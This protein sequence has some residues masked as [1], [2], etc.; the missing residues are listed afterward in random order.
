MKIQYFLPTRFS[1]IPFNKTIGGV[2]VLKH[3][4]KSFKHSAE[5]FKHSLDLLKP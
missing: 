1:E 2:F 3:A 4:A 5:F